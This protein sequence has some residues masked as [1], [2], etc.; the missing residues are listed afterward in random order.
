MNKC[1]IT[2]DESFSYLSSDIM[3]GRPNVGISIFGQAYVNLEASIDTKNVFKRLGNG[4]IVDEGG[5]HIKYGIFEDIYPAGVSGNYG[6]IVYRDGY[7]INVKNGHVVNIDNCE[8][9]KARYGIGGAASPFI[10]VTA[11]DIN[12][13]EQGILLYKMDASYI[14]GNDIVAKERCIYIGFSKT[15]YYYNWHSIFDNYLTIA[16]D[17]QNA[18]AVEAE[19]CERP[20]LTNNRI[21]INDNDA[22]VYCVN[23]IYNDM[24]NN[25]IIIKDG[26][27]YNHTDGQYLSNC[28]DYSMERNHY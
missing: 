19:S 9:S 22:G 3:Y 20:R 27:G 17:E 18:K 10:D 14:H 1:L 13:V 21:Y 7:A 11:C 23:S 24:E 6:N 25:T 16:G 15:K 5:F 28:A 2:S 4:I 8:I 12:D 26:S